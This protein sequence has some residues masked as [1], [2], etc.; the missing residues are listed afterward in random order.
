MTLM[1]LVEAEVEQRRHNPMYMQTSGSEE[2]QGLHR[3]IHWS[4]GPVKVMMEPPLMYFGKGT[5]ES[6]YHLLP[7]VPAT[8]KARGGGVDNGNMV[9]RDHWKQFNVNYEFSRPF[10]HE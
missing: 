1:E 3:R 7:Q 10:S 9:R 4:T 5:E 2:A 6:V 8:E